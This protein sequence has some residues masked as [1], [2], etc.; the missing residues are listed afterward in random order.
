MSKK[1]LA[2][3]QKALAEARAAAAAE[4][5]SW[6]DGAKKPN[7]KKLEEEAKKAAKAQKKAEADEALDAEMAEASKPGK[8]TGNKV[9][10]YASLSS[11]LTQAE[12]AANLEADKA[13]AAKQKDGDG[14]YM[15]KLEENTNSLDAIN[16]S[17]LDDALAALDAANDTKVDKVKLRA[18]WEAFET[19]ELPRVKEE[20]PGL[21]L[22]QYKEMVWKAWQKSPQNPLRQ[23][24]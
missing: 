1:A 10:K 7:A 20:K 3:E 9:N 24:G 17:S 18:A 21:K 4:A 23:R 13:A 19:A 6:E 15:G 8:Q 2:E 5:A 12:V 22:Q 11:K 16:A 14:D